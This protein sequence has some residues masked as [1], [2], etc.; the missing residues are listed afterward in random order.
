MIVAELEVFHSRPVAPTRRVA[1]GSTL[2]PMDP[3]P[4]HGAMLLAAI[5]ATFAPMLDVE[6]TD[7]YT[8]LLRQIE[9]GQRISQPRLRHRFQQDRVGLTRSSHRLLVEG[10]RLRF[11]IEKGTGT[12]EQFL[13]AAA[14]ACAPMSITHRAA[15]IAAINVG[16]TWRGALDGRFVSRVMGRSTNVAMPALALSDPVGWALR[17]LG[18]DADAKIVS[19]ATVQ[20]RFRERLRDAHPDHGAKTDGAAERIADLAE[21]RRILLA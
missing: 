15:A 12:P 6:L 13:L 7:D 14:Y 21:A 8:K 4:G 16:V 1:V 10:S 18:I 9:R 2:L 5:A 19:K 3:P 17:I 11:R 20:R